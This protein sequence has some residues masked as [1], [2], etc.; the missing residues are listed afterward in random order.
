MTK[1]RDFEKVMKV[2]NTC[3]TVDHFRAAEKMINLYKKMHGD[4]AYSEDLNFYLYKKAH[5]TL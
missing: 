5:C 1:L 3:K 2:I 4:N